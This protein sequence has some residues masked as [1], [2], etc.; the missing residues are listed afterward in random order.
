MTKR[1]TLQITVT[2]P[3]SR[4]V[5][6][7]GKPVRSI[8][9][10]INELMGILGGSV[11]HPYYVSGMV[12]KNPATAV[13]SFNG[14]GSDAVVEING[15]ALA[16]SGSDDEDFANNLV[17]AVNTKALGDVSNF[18]KA[19]KLTDT[20]VLIESKLLGEFGNAITISVDGEGVTASGSRLTGG[21][22]EESFTKG[23]P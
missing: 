23:K 4:K 7:R 8:T 13:V 9:A 2:F 1:T 20:D 18:V 14:T 12:A 5:F 15:V 6:E 19:E 11:K 16:L 22:S 17:E 3:D 21:E 10:F